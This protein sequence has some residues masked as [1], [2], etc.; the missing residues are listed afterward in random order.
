MD[1]T[2]INCKELFQKAYEKRYNWNNEFT[3]YK[4]K[5]FFSVNN[6][7]HEGKF[8]LNKDFK[9]EIQNIEDKEVVKSI[10]SQ[11]FEYDP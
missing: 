11:L 7:N 4:G 2:E 8:V 6:D 5:C 9:T 1:L 3:G 10:S